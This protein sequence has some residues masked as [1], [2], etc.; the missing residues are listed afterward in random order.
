MNP[1]LVLVLG[2]LA[3]LLPAGAAILLISAS[4][5]QTRQAPV[6]WMLVGCACLSAALCLVGL[7]RLHLAE[8]ELA[9]RQR[10]LARLAEEQLE[11][12]RLDALARLAAG[13]AHEIGQPL[14]A[15]RV[16][17]EGLH[18]LRQLGREPEPAYLD[19]AI[20]RVGRNLIAITQTIEHLRSLASPVPAA[21][22]QEVEVAALVSAVVAERESWLRFQE[23]Q[24]DWTPPTQPVMAL[25]DPVGLRLILVNL[26]RNAA[27]AMAAQGEGRRVVRVVLHPGGA[28]ARPVLTVADS[29]PGIPAHLLAGIFD[30]FVSTKAG[31]R[32]IGLSLARASATAMGAELTA[33][34]A[35]GTGATLTLRLRQPPAGQGA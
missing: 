30:P 4:P 27:E 3:A 18:Y 23:L 12:R 1:R 7:W 21:Q 28:A 15:A 14:S 6:T 25:A 29:G 26:L 8:A 13:L 5:P 9:R 34:S 22:V 17:I 2:A 10:E 33:A 20:D 11:A 31:G 16:A 19:R 32:G 24:L 35:P